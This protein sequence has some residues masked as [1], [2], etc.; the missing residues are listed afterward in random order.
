MRRA[1]PHYPKRNLFN[2]FH[3]KD[4]ALDLDV[5][6]CHDCPA[7][8]DD[9]VPRY[10]EFL[11]TS[12]SLYV[13]R[14]SDVPLIATARLE[15]YRDTTEQW[16][17]LHGI[18]YQWLLMGP[19]KLLAERTPKRVTRFKAEAY[20]NSAAQIFVE[21]CPRQAGASPIFPPSVIRPASAE[22]F[23]IIANV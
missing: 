23:N 12:Q 15:K 21:S 6:L 5:I 3:T 10:A 1:L 13:P 17:T 7:R 19:W 8:D 11:R 20:R 4:L 14:H 2:G 9:D 18:Q 22:V 16:L